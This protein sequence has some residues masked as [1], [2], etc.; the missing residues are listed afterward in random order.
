V[1]MLSFFR[2]GAAVAGA[3][4]MVGSWFARRWAVG[5]GIVEHAVANQPGRQFQIVTSSAALA[6]AQSSSCWALP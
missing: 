1:T 6:H 3:M 5:L 2:S 4:V